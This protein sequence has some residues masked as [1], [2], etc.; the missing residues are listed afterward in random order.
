MK[1]ALILTGQFRN[2]SETYPYIKGRIL[3]RFNPDVFISTWDPSDT[4]KSSLQADTKHLTDSL[5][6]D[7]VLQLLKPK[8]FLSQNFDSP[9]IQ[10]TVNRAKLYIEKSPMNGE[11]N[12]VSVFSMWYKIKNCLDLMLD[13]EKETGERYDLI[14]K[15]RFD[16][17]FHNNIPIPE[18][19]TD[20]LIP[21]GY[22]WR[23]GINDVFAF[24]ARDSMLYYCSL[25]N[26][27]EKYIAEDN[28]FFHPETLLKHHLNLSGYKVIRPDIKVSLRG[29]KVWEKE[30][31]R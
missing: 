29:S 16:L 12:P 30:V 24:G 18:Y 25:F 5:T 3:D 11:M 2:L 6:A 9:E 27:I 22:D 31:T 26:S 17:K 10:E 28:V 23:G 21:P 1:I 4:I 8:R 14:I 7:E 13:Y 15:G 20:I 19:S